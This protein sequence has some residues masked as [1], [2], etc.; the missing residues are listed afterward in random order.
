MIPDADF[1]KLKSFIETNTGITIPESNY[2]QVR[3]YISEKMEQYA[4]DIDSYILKIMRDEDE[5]ARLM[6]AV[7]INETYFFREE[8]HFH[9]LKNIHLPQL[10]RTQEEI[11]IWSSSCSSGEEALSLYVL[12]REIF[13]EPENTRIFASDIS[14]NMLEYFRRGI[15]RPNS[16]R[17]DG[18]GLTQLIKFI[19]AEQSDNMWKIDP[20]HLE[21]INI[22][23]RNLFLPQSADLPDMDIIF[24]RNTLIY[25]NMKNKR[26]IIDNVVSKLKV[27]G[28]LFLSAAELPLISHPSLKIEYSGDAY[29]FRKEDPLL[30]SKT[31]LDVRINHAANQKKRTTSASVNKG[32]L[33]Q[34]TVTNTN[35]LNENE[36]CNVVA[37]RL[38]NEVY[39]KDS[40]AVEQTV[41]FIIRI[42][43][44]ISRN[45]TALTENLLAALSR[46]READNVPGLFHFFLGGIQYQK[47]QFREAEK[48][49]RKALEY[50]GSLWPARFFLIKT[51]PP[52]NDEQKKQIRCLKNEISDYI[53]GHR[54]DYQF[55]LEGFN[56]RYFLMICEKMYTEAERRYN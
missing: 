31:I 14:N 27:G 10:R 32:A 16:F 7:T 2:Q 33:K 38:N 48:L 5:Y 13:R 23:H 1:T 39:R 44:C 42:L 8:K 3:N 12:S 11:S 40:V 17:E 26:I 30:L 4:P 19:A 53:N 36:I 49:Y 43:N 46:C 21:R 37:M 41:E 54:W 6:E 50:N 35:K 22:H 20:V 25:M 18:S 52:E 9:Y 15:Y 29:F 55:L 28:L 45:E 56:A 34:K 51:L 24:L 47:G